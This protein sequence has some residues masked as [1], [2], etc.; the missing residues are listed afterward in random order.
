M[1]SLALNNWAQIFM[2]LKMKHF[3]WKRMIFLHPHPKHR[4]QVPS[5]LPLLGSSNKQGSTLHVRSR[6]KKN[7]VYPGKHLS[8]LHKWDLSGSSCTQ[9]LISRLN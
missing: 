3:R 4:L 6:N 2:A 1:V 9:V 8:F 7:N 5:E